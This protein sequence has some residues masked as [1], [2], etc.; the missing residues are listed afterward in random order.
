M[1]PGQLV[2]LLGGSGSGKSTIASLLSRFYDVTSG[3]ITIDGI[4]IRDVTLASLRKN[5]GVAQQ[6]VFLF[7]MSIRDNIA[8]GIPNA[9]MEQIEAAAKSAQI[10]DFMQTLPYGYDTEVGER[11]QPSPEARNNDW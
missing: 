7:S 1:K 3:R 2:A 9:T 4:D 5:V 10:H 11:A 6:D 8:Y